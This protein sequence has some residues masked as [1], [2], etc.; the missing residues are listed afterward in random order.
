[1]L[2]VDVGSSITSAKGTKFV[3]PFVRGVWSASLML[4]VWKS[5]LAKQNLKGTCSTCIRLYEVKRRLGELL[6]T[7]INKNDLHIPI[8]PMT[9][10]V[11]F[12]LNLP[13]L[14]RCL[15]LEGVRHCQEGTQWEDPEDLKVERPGVFT[16]K[17]WKL[18]AG[19][20]LRQGYSYP[21]QNPQESKLPKV[22]FYRAW[23]VPLWK[24]IHVSWFCFVCSVVWRLWIYA[25]NDLKSR[26][27]CYLNLG[28]CTE[29]HFGSCAIYFQPPFTT[30]ILHHSRTSVALL[31]DHWYWITFGNRPVTKKSVTVAHCCHGRRHG[32]Q[33]LRS[34]T[35][36]VS[37][38]PRLLW[39][40]GHHGQQCNLSP[41]LMGKTTLK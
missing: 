6:N 33:T 19:P 21:N 7:E 34:L 15:E 37:G 18:L 25:L 22:H 3:A 13:N 39:P 35:V 41:Q 2:L 16:L 14:H 1:M 30:E 31:T 11:F 8:K 28:P 23:I 36:S 29:P 26:Y 10:N 38:W 20:G 4:G 40:R 27:L 17:V 9:K 5:H 32:S 12:T 24:A